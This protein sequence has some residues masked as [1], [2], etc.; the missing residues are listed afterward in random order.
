MPRHATP[1]TDPRTRL[2][3]FGLV[4]G[5]TALAGGAHDGLSQRMFAALIEARRQ[6]QH[7]VCFYPIAG[8]GAVEGGLAL[9][10]RAGLV[11]DQRVDLAEV[12]DRRG[13]AEQHALGRGLAR[14][15]HDRHGRGQPQRTGTGD[16]EDG[17]RVDEAVDPA[18][19]GAEEAPEEEGQ[20]GR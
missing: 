5:E 16:D 20:Q 9:G 8:Y 19:L 18:R 14:G 3:S 17:H 4:E 2:E 7:L 10:E 12:L 1:H 6:S 13:V 11:D 15:D